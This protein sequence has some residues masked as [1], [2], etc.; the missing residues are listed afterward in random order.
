MACQLFCCPLV[1]VVGNEGRATGAVASAS[2]MCAIGS[3][4]LERPVLVNGS[5]AHTGKVYNRA[6]LMHAISTAAPGSIFQ[7]IKATSIIPDPR[8]TR[9]LV[10]QPPSGTSTEFTYFVSDAS[11]FDC[12]TVASTVAS[13]APTTVPIMTSQLL[14][15][16]DARAALSHLQEFKTVAANQL[17]SSRSYSLVTNPDLLYS[18]FVKYSKVS[19]AL[20]F[21]LHVTL[22]PP[23]L[24]VCNA[25]WVNLGFRV[26][27]ARWSPSLMSC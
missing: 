2:S 9:L 13:L 24:R 3:G 7:G 20:L 8:T 26:C 22:S 18:L 15:G 5:L 27:A 14:R 12:D 1:C 23:E 16:E 11:A 6:A 21:W 25:E 17:S 19:R 10:L 4:I